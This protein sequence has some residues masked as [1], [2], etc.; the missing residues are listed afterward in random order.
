MAKL[1]SATRNRLPTSVFGLP[2]QRKYPEDRTH[3]IK[4]EEFATKED[5]GKT[6]AS[7]GCTDSSEGQATLRRAALR[8]K[9]RGFRKLIAGKFDRRQ[10]S[11]IAV[12]RPQAIVPLPRRPSSTWI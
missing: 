2:K 11:G 3:Q 1:K 9:R 5:A 4:A 7:P 6:L 8:L 10:V 12:S